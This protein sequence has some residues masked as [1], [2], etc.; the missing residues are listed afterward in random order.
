MSL[1][2]RFCKRLAWA[3][4]AFSIA[5]CLS[6]I[7]R[8]D[9]G[10]WFGFYALHLVVFIPF[11]TAVRALHEMNGTCVVGLQDWQRLRVLLPTS[12]KR[13]FTGTALFAALVIGHEIYQDL[14][15][16][17]CESGFKGP[18]SMPVEWKTWITPV[19]P[20]GF[21]SYGAFWA[22]FFLISACLLTMRE[23]WRGPES[24]RKRS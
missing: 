22:V 18:K 13:L 14:I 6:A 19:A 12:L 7:F 4:Y 24:T 23:N 15:L 8:P 17:S 21:V 2:R 11:V 5:L 16:K 9:H 10:V 1:W 3:G 20:G